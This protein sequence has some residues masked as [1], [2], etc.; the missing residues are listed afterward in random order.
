LKLSAEKTEALW[1]GS[2]YENDEPP[3]I[4][5]EKVNVPI[6]I[7]GVYFT[8][9]CRKKQQL[10]FDEILTSLSKTLKGWQWRN[11]R[12]LSFLNLCFA[13]SICLTKNK[14]KQV[15]CIIYNF[16]WKGR[17]KIK[18]LAL[19]SEYKD[20]GLRMPHIQSLIDTQRIMCLKKYSKDNESP[21]KQMLSHFLKNYGGKLLLQCNFSVDDLPD[22]LPNFYKEC[23]AVWSNLSVKPVLTR[24]QAKS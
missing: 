22:C 17:D 16:I 4:S 2:N 18:R 11:L 7:L 1:L 5:I 6:K 21:W 3:H 15:N 24:E 9:D 20:G 13:S 19:I 23:F 8:Y 14:I 12:L 10:N